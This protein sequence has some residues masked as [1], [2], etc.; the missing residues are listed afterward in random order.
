MTR[1]QFL[2]LPL[3]FYGQGAGRV[4]GN[5]VVSVVEPQEFFGIHGLFAK[6]SEQPM[7]EPFALM[8]WIEDQHQLGLFVGL[9]GKAMR[10]VTGYIDYSSRRDLRI[11]AP[12]LYS[13]HS[14]GDDKS[15]IRI[16][17]IMQACADGLRLKDHFIHAEL[18]VRM[19]AG[20]FENTGVA[21]QRQGLSL[22]GIDHDSL[23]G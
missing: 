10:S 8:G 22:S 19:C 11:L 5:A 17:V 13:Q 18:A 7:E 16:P 21:S 23:V 1:E 12:E 2:L 3:L 6:Y 20:H 15:F 14:P 4:H 9:I